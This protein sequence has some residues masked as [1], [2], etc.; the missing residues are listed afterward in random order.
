MDFKTALKEGCICLNLKSDSKR[1][2]IEEMIDLMAA[3]GKLKN[4]DEAL[5]AVLEREDKMSTGVQHG[6]AIPHG[7]LASIEGLITAFA[8]KR[9]GVDFGSLDG[10]PSRIFVMTISSNLRT[11]PHL[12][13]L[14]GI[15]QMLNSESVRE[16]LLAAASVEEVVGILTS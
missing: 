3:A 15:C 10:Q 8:I 16:R 6:V 5:Q 12:Q 13:F 2:V 9:E 1:G 7:K 4:R 11:G 14:S